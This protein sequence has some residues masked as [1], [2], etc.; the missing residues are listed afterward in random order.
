MVNQKFLTEKIKNEHLIDVKKKLRQDLLGKHICINIIRD[1]ESATVVTKWNIH[2]SCH[3]RAYK[4]SGQVWLGLFQNCGCHIGKE[5][6]VDRQQ[7]DIHQSLQPSS[8]WAFGLYE[9][10]PP[11]YWPTCSYNPTTSRLQLWLDIVR[12]NI[13]TKFHCNF[14][15][16]YVVY[17]VFPRYQ[18]D[19]V[20]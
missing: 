18:F 7:I 3:L 10:K 11:R 4:H 17:M 6:V 15:I 16:N 13:L 20:T 5:Q 9:L 19:L 8:P 2:F 12:T 14:S 1:D